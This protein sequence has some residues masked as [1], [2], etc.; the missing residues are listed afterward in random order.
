MSDPAEAFAAR[1]VSVLNDASLALMISI[2]HQVE[3]FDAMATLPA[4]T[5]PRSPP[6]QACRNATCASGSRP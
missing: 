6:R 4:S 1:M 5:L 3:L 2:G